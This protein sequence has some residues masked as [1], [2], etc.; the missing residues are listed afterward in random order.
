MDELD[1]LI[2]DSVRVR[3]CV[4][5][6]PANAECGNAA[7]ALRAEDNDSLL[8]AFTPT[9][10]P[11][12]P[13]AEYGPS[14]TGDPPDERWLVGEDERW[15]RAPS[16]PLVVGDPASS[17]RGA[18]PGAGRTVS[19]A[20]GGGFATALGG[21]CETPRKSGCGRRMW[22][23]S[24]RTECAEGGREAVEGRLGRG[25]CRGESVASHPLA[26]LLLLV[27][28][29]VIVADDWTG[30]DSVRGV[31]GRRAS[32]AGCCCC[33]SFAGVGC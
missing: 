8:L 29:V 23:W 5:V 28:A 16:A 22:A 31:C 25:L 27:V 2:V 17:G 32:V 24:L 12:Y 26:L 10:A 19:G 21:P 3:S 13:P 14:P 7:A 6:P 4:H 11:T 30:S 33:W 9:P 15:N 20:S 18:A 1:V